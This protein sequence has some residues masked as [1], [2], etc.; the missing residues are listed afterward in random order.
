MIGHKFVILKCQRLRLYEQAT[1]F[2]KIS[3]LAISEYI[4]F[5][6]V[7]YYF[8]A[9]GTIYVSIFNF[10][11][12]LFAYLTYMRNPES[13]LPNFYCEFIMVLGF[14]GLLVIFV[15][16][17][18]MSKR[19]RNGLRGKNAAMVAKY[20]VVKGG[21]ISEGIFSLAQ[22]LKNPDPITISKDFISWSFVRR[23][24]VSSKSMSKNSSEILSNQN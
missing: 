6:G 8:Q 2:Q 19:F 15:G 3:C 11:L 21:K 7:S 18:L 14:F 1:I 13:D 12:W 22:I 4:N 20:K 16:Y 9:R 23:Q 24:I 17:G 10:L 5:K